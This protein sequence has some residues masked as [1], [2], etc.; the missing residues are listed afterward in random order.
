MSIVMSLVHYGRHLIPLGPYGSV[1][2][3]YLV[4]LPVRNESKSL[5]A[6]A[7]RQA[8]RAKAPALLSVSFRQI[9]NV[10]IKKPCNKQDNVWLLGQYRLIMSRQLL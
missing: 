1:V 6:E 7:G 10:F 4:S 2:S 9:M 8:S 5:T 3:W